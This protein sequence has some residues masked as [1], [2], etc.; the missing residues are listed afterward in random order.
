MWPKKY[1]PQFGWT[2]ALGAIVSDASMVTKF[3]NMELDRTHIAKVYE[4]TGCF[5]EIWLRR[6]DAVGY[7]LDIYGGFICFVIIG[8]KDRSI[9]TNPLFRHQLL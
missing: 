6:P 5:P 8:G 4:R 1:T 9:Q 2:E 3:E 7:L